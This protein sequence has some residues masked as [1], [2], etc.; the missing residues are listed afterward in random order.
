MD[1]KNSRVVLGTYFQKC[2]LLNSSAPLQ[3]YLLKFA[4][5]FLRQSGFLIVKKVVK[6]CK[7]AFFYCGWSIAPSSVITIS[8]QFQN[9]GVILPW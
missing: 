2:P 9:H 8:S 1:K 5:T 7:K 6:K 3:Y 4:I